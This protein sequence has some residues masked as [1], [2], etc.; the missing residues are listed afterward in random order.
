ML[1][2]TYSKI[3]S[4]FGLVRKEEMDARIQEVQDYE[5]TKGFALAHRDI[6]ETMVDD[7]EEKS[8]EKAKQLLNDLLSPVDLKAV[9]ALDS[10]TRQI[11]IGG[12]PAEAARL[13]NLKS[14]AEFLVE[15]DLWKL[16]HETPKELAQR[17]MFVDG[18]SL[19]DMQKGRSILYV[20]ATQKR[21]V[22][23]L[24]SV[25]PKTPESAR[26]IV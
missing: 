9:V 3:L 11:H 13:A 10:R 7:T 2:H 24:R 8:Q 18:K 19:D 6:R 22:E 15:S 21:I 14:E 5:R 16:L 4:L 23:L 20:L 25:I 26:S 17:A 1:L 12:E